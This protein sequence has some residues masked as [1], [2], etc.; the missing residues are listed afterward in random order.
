MLVSVVVPVYNREKFI[1]VAVAC[2]KN[3]ICR[4]GQHLEFILI[5]DGSTDRTL[6][7][8]LSL[9]L[10]SDSRF[11]IVNIENQGYGHACNLGFELSSGD[12]VSVFEPDDQIDNDF[13]ST[14]MDYAKK[15]PDA[16][17]LRYRGLLQISGNT[18][19]TLYAWK[20]KI[21]NRLLDVLSAPR[22]WKSH[23]SVFNGM[24]SRKFIM[25]NGIKFC[26]T[27]LASYQDVTFMV[28][29]Y[30]MNPRILIID[31]IKY[32]YV[33]HDGQ[34]VKCA[35]DRLQY[36]FKNWLEEKKWLSERGIADFS[37]FN[38]RMVRQ[39][40]GILKGNPDIDRDTVMRSVRRLL[41]NRCIRK[42]PPVATLRERVLWYYFSLKARRF[43]KTPRKNRSK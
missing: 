14:L 24:Y 32:T 27:P 18:K 10:E 23:T 7:I 39:Y 3:Q 41:R 9:G 35:S 34:S 33:C 31:D 8:I 42:F 13:Y 22:I 38:Y 6:K 19:K 25:D 26:E 30:Y 28:S 40:R 12:Y 36:V 43:R 16:D 5:N 20:S 4:D 11:K 29:L 37:F 2:L 17:V 21:T 15:F 1:S